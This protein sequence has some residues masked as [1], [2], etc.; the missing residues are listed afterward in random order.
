MGGITMAPRWRVLLQEQLNQGLSIAAIALKVGIARPTMSLII[1][2]SGPYGNGQAS[3]K[4][5]EKKVLAAFDNFACPHLTS[6]RGEEVVINGELCKSYA[7]RQAPT[8]TSVEIRHW[9]A[10]QGC[11]L[12]PAPL[13]AK[14]VVHRK[15][16]TEVEHVE[17]S[18]D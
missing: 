9:Q 11:K 16:K 18:A 14:V 6:E 12:K 4:N 2:N 5:V 15:K 7:L 1:S 17:K 3:T 10:C 8:G 13:V